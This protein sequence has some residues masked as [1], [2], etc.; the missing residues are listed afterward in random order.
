MAPP[1]EDLTAQGYDLM[2]GTNALGHFYL[3][4]LLL[5]TLLS[6]MKQSGQQ[7]R[8]V[9]LS[10]MAHHLGNLDFS[11]FTDTP[12]RRKRYSFALYGQSKFV[13]DLC[14]IRCL[15]LCF[16]APGEHCIRSGACKEIW[17]PRSDFGVRASWFYSK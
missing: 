10:S 6:T 11:T 7:V 2:L 14:E 3:T 12:P 8:V 16:I 4:K 5:P 9:T 17:R 13:R 15:G 1:M